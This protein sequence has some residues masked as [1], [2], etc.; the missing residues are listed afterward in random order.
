MIVPAVVSLNVR[1]GRVTAGLAWATFALSLVVAL[2]AALEGFFSYGERWRSF[3]RT[4]WHRAEGLLW[5]MG[6]APAYTAR[7]LGG[8]N[9]RSRFW[10]AGVTAG[11]VGRTY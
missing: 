11:D 6:A 10:C 3:R 8:L 1:E 7:R 4:S 2:S 9:R 5:A